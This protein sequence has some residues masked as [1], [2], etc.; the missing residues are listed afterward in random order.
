MHAG[1]RFGQEEGLGVGIDGDEV[2][3]GN[4]GFDHAVNGVT[5]AAADADDTNLGE[6]I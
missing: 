6:V 5:A 4:T 3:A 2:Y 1:G